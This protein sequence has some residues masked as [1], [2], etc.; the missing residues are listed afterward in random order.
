MPDPAG[1]I[2]LVTH[3]L[4]RMPCGIGRYIEAL[5]EE[6][7]ALDL[8]KRIHLVHDQP[9]S[10]PH[11]RHYPETIVPMP[12]GPTRETRWAQ[13][14]LPRVLRQL[15]PSLVHFPAQTNPPLFGV[16]APLVLTVHDLIPL[17]WREPGWSPLRRWLI[18]R[19]ILPRAIRHASAVI[20]PSES[21]ATVLARFLGK[22]MKNWGD[23]RIVVVPE[24]A[25]RRLRPR[26]DLER[27]AAGPYLLYVGSLGP[28]KNVGTLIRA[29]ALLKEKGLAHRLI[30]VTSRAGFAD[31]GLET[32]ARAQRLMTLI[33]VRE[34]VS[35]DDLAVLYTHCE[36]FVF[37]SL[38]EGFGLPVL[39][40]MACG[41]PVITTR[42]S[43]LAEVAGE[44]ALVVSGRD[45]EELARAI[46]D[47]VGKP[48]LRSRLSQA[49]LAQAARFSWRRAAEQTAAVFERVMA[50]RT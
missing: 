5:L 8:G 25:D 37:P 44:A 30:L 21:T 6:F 12:R 11:Y 24:A 39:E 20:V 4:D 41:A 14:H 49:G 50:R 26:R 34:G 33:E 43:S 3:Y 19:L 1:K 16:P 18:Y 2:C 36:T 32:L 9:N 42:C 7:K 48:A 27:P 10:H 13:W 38:D 40:A 31:S 15:K 29:V 47:V 22:E 46:Q 35:T 17:V 28:H 45:P 23:Q